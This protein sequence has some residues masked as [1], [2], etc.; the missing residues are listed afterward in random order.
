MERRVH[1]EAAQ[2]NAIA[3]R[4]RGCCRGRCRAPMHTKVARQREGAHAATAPPCV[5]G[6]L[7][8]A[9]GDRRSVPPAP[10]R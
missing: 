4:P 10:T 2:S 9:A 1:A 6:F 8:R 7:T 3:L 5:T